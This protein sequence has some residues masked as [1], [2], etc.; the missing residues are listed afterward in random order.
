MLNYRTLANKPTITIVK[1]GEA[2]DMIDLATKSI[3]GNVLPQSQ[4]VKVNRHYIA[5]PDLIS[6]ALYGSD[7]YADVICKMNGLSNP[8]E[9]NEGMILMCPTL[10][11]ISDM[12]LGSQSPQ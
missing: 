7:D 6:L 5:R 2:T 8:F 9:L 10:S 1:D 11:S 4:F 3:K 12:V